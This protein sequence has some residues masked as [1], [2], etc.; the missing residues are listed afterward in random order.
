VAASQRTRLLAAVASTVAEKGYAGAGIAEIS[1]RAGV[2]PTTFYAHFDGKLGALLAGYDALATTL[3]EA[4]AAAVDPDA[5]WHEFVRASLGAYLA[6]LEANPDAARAFLVESDAAGPEAR[7]RRRDTYA[8]FAAVVKHRHEE[9]RAT[10]PSLGPL[11]DRVYLAIV[12]GVRELVGD[13][14][15]REPSPRLTEMTDDVVLWVTA[16]VA[17]AAAAQ[18]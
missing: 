13:A 10:D 3:L 7:R 8:A 18:G 12:L 9:I 4:I 14:L 2:S 5:G 11:P 15:E 6:T 17:G 1:R 16:T